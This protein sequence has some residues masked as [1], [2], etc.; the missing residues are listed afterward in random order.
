MFGQRRKLTQPEINYIVKYYGK[1]PTDVIAAVLDRTISSVQVSFSL[2]ASSEQRKEIKWYKKAKKFTTTQIEQWKA[3]GSHIPEYSYEQ[4]QHKEFVNWEIECHINEKGE[5]TA[6]LVKKELEEDEDF[7][8]VPVM[9]PPTK[10]EK[11]PE[12]DEDFQRKFKPVTKI[13]KEEL[14]TFPAEEEDKPVKFRSL[15]SDAHSRQ[16]KPITESDKNYI[17]ENYGHEDAEEVAEHLGWMKGGK[18]DV[19]KV[20]A[21][22]SNNA[23]RDQKAEFEERFRAR[24]IIRKRAFKARPA[25]SEQLSQGQPSL[26]PPPVMMPGEASNL[27]WG[28]LLTDYYFVPPSRSIEGNYKTY[29]QPKYDWRNKSKVEELAQKINNELV[30]QLK[31]A[32][33]IGDQTITNE[34]IPEK[35]LEKVNI[36]LGL[37]DK[38]GKPPHHEYGECK[39]EDKIDKAVR[40]ISVVYRYNAAGG[41]GHIVFDD[42][43]LADRYIDFCLGMCKDNENNHIPEQLKAEVEALEFLKTL[44]MSERNKVCGFN[45]TK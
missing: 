26:P 45:P 23:T 34:F 11:N 29:Y 41:Y 15:E 12:E 35:P 43:N 24:G 6:K 39:T 14:N 38:C 9:Y 17:F 22:I 13:S 30:D 27:L 36:K 37:C 32:G 18:P 19:K 21:C 31:E 42:G 10:E 28:D 20:R 7:T 8:V 5:A 44:T 3:E 25:G 33:I 16:W 40:L 4:V 2:N 1:I